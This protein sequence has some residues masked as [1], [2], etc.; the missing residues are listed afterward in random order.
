MKRVLVVG[1]SQSGQLDRILD[2]IVA[3]LGADGAVSVD[4][5][6]L[7]GFEHF[8][9][10]W[11]FWAFLD[12]FPESVQQDAPP[13]RSVPPLADDYDL[14]VLGYQV[15]FLS[16]SLPVTAFLDHP[17]AQRLLA[18]KPV[19]AVVACRNMWMG[20]WQKLRARLAAIGARVLDH[21]VL[22]DQGP[23]LA[24]FI[25]TPRWL[26]TGRRDPIWGM[27]AAGVS[28]AQ[29][30]GAARFGEAL[31]LALEADREQGS[32]PLL[33]G[34][35]AVTVEPRL[36]MSER[37]GARAFGV[38]SRLVR[39]VGKAGQRRR[40]PVLLLFLTY[41]VLAIV[42]IVPLSLALQSLLAPLLRKRFDR[43]R[44]EFEAPSGSGTERIKSHV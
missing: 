6:Q 17:A 30:E 34:L 19:V 1:G 20:A 44:A 29:I 23:T 15:W 41:L 31:R 35:S 38:W 5:W 21:V 3:P 25:T 13:L 26:L 7:D 11:G 4:R 33:H 24:T 2:R 42:T 18:G 22:V 39:A 40:R 27:P 16:P 37:A 9:F 36:A 32:A 43:I 10:P 8:P 12:A 28:E 14:I